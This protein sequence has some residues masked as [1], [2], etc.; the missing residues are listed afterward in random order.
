MSRGNLDKLKGV[1][2]LNLKRIKIILEIGER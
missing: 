1:N 2:E